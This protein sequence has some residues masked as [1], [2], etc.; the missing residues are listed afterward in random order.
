MRLL[1][2]H[3]AFSIRTFLVMKNFF[4]TLAIVISTPAIVTMSANMD[5]PAHDEEG[6]VE[7]HV[8]ADSLCEALELA[9]RIA[10]VE[11]KGECEVVAVQGSKGAKHKVS[12]LI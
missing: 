1:L 8:Q 12:V 9:G 10:R 6:E 4:F 2:T 3:A 5:L 7:L 11:Y